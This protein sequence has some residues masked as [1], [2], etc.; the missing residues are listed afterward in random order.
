MNTRV[1]FTR[2]SERCPACPEKKNALSPSGLP[3]WYILCVAA[4]VWKAPALVG[5]RTRWRITH[6][7]NLSSS[8][9][10]QVSHVNSR[11]QRAGC[12]RERLDLFLDISQNSSGGTDTA[13]TTTPNFSSV[14]FAINSLQCLKMLISVGSWYCTEKMIL[15]KYLKI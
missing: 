10:R 6:R 7:A 8:N 1:T 12:V 14:F 11:N 3:R 15:L 5:V 9:I 13:F 4:S 2:K